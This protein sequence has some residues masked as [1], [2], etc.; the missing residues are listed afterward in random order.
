ML[1]H[2][3]NSQFF[4]LFIISCFNLTWSIAQPIEEKIKL[5]DTIFYSMSD[6]RIVI[7]IDYESA[8]QRDVN[9]HEFEQPR[10]M[11][12]SQ[13]ISL[14]GRNVI[15]ICDRKKSITQVF[16]S[17]Q[18]PGYWTAILKNKI[19]GWYS[20]SSKEENF[21]IKHFNTRPYLGNK[22]VRTHLN[23]RCFL[24]DMVNPDPPNSINILD[25]KHLG[26]IDSAG[27][28]IFPII[29]DYIELV[30]S[31]YLVKKDGLVG[32][33]NR[34]SQIVVPLIYESASVKLDGSVIFESKGKVKKVYKSPSGEQR[35]L[36]DYDWIDENRLDDP[37][38]SRTSDL[39]MVWKNGKYGFVN[40][41]FKVAIPV[42]YD[43]AGYANPEGLIRVCLNKK[44]GFLNNKGEMIIQ[45]EY[46]DAI[47][48]YEGR[49]IV[50]KSGN[51]FCID[52]LG[53][54]TTGCIARYADWKI[55]EGGGYNQYIK[56]R[57]IVSRDYQK[58][59]IDDFGRLVCPIIYNHIRG[60]ESNVS[61]YRWS[62]FFYKA[63][64]GKRW[65]IL[66]KDG[67]VM[68]PFIYDEIND[69]KGG[70]NSIL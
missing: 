68:V 35:T 56:G 9:W 26:L 61:E 65:G 33:I 63:A 30:G 22:R 24:V 58:G 16:N 2:Y 48:F 11:E 39:I 50:R 64:I 17:D 19:A 4:I 66:D 34:Q 42:I 31:D 37:V 12:W 49:T 29:Y 36:D 7:E 23:N 15:I 3:R 43:F 53:R 44:W 8:W 67:A 70:W 69:F 59:V 57:R 27:D 46:D 41:N 21:L 45:F 5:P 14:P 28:F 40:R 20:K 6:N 25:G 51:S 38:T 1:S 10:A 62:K 18:P 32:I 13:L 60:L 52:K 55:T 54:E 47:E